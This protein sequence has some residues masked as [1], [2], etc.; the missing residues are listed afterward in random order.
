MNYERKNAEGEL[1]KKLEVPTR[2]DFENS[3]NP[4]Y[5]LFREGPGL[6]EKQ[7]QQRGVGGIAGGNCTV[8]AVKYYRN[9]IGTGRPASTREYTRDKLIPLLLVCEEAEV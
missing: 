2:E 5:F 1:L 9:V 4:G 6:V 3:S 7:H 8:F